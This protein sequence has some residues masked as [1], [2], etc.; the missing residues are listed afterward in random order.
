V[1]TIL[2][3]YEEAGVIPESFTRLPVEAVQYMVGSTRAGAPLGELLRER[4]VRDTAGNLLPETWERLTQT[5]VNGT[6]MGQNPR[7]VAR[8]MRDDLAGGLQKALLI[9]R[10]EGL[11]PYREASRLQYEESGVVE[12]HKRLAA[13]DGNTCAA[14]IAEEGQEF[15]VT[16][17]L[18]DHPNGRCTSVPVVTG[19]PPVEWT[20]GEAWFVLQDEE[21][22]RGILGPGLFEA[23]KEGAFKLGDVAQHTFDP[24]WGGSLTPRSLRELAGDRGRGGSRKKP[25]IEKPAAKEPAPAQA[26]G[27]KVSKALQTPTRG[28]Y[29]KVYQGALDSIDQVHGDGELP[30]IP[31]KTRTFRNGTRGQYVHNVTRGTAVRIDVDPKGGTAESTLAHEAGHFLDHQAIGGKGRFESNAAARGQQS[32]LQGWWEAVEKSAAVQDLRDRRD[33]PADYQ[34]AQE[35]KLGGET[36]TY[37]AKP[38]R[39]FLDYLLDPCE[40]WARSY[41]QYIGVRSDNSLMRKQMAQARKDKLY[42]GT[43]WGD[44]DFEPIA[45]AIDELFEV[46]GW[47][48]KK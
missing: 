1:R 31:V 5:L 3:E 41:A 24:V 33:R 22:Q 15:P 14:C 34:V 11:R 17:T 2:A 23:W 29:N 7:T 44:E 27:K 13:H 18:Y 8:L 39:R 10:T 40:L 38:S 32:V 30:E 6:A 45:R 28:K 47:L 37:T 48:K 35:Y 12:R 26:V 16:A 9:A 43:S 36:M 46:L 4:M 20:A 21:T 25:T 42:P 19:L